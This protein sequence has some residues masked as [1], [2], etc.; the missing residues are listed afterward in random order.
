MWTCVSR[1]K[2]NKTKSHTAYCRN[3]IVCFYG[4]NRQMSEDNFRADSNQTHK[5]AF[6]QVLHEDTFH[7]Q[8]VCPRLTFI[9]FEL[10]VLFLKLMIWNQYFYHRRTGGFV[11][12]FLYGFGKRGDNRCQIPKNDDVF[13]Y[14]KT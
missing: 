10:L 4:C 8:E 13:I 1:T 9:S 12:F 7:K 11:I 2:Q 14:L 3:A 5:G 6:W